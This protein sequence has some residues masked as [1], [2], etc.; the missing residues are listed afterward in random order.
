MLYSCK[1]VLGLPMLRPESW[2]AV[3]W[4]GLMS[5]VDASYTAYLVPLSFAYFHDVRI[6]N[7]MSVLDIIGSKLHCLLLRS[8]SAACLQRYRVVHQN[9]RQ[10]TRRISA[11][12]LYL[13]DV[14]FNFH[15]GIVLTKSLH[16]RLLLDG[17][18]VAKL[19]I[20]HSTFFV[21]LVA[22]I[23][24]PLEV[25]NGKYLCHVLW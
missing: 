5:I 13:L 25:S 17:V 6:F 20:K 10:M 9:R 22:A 16:S 21:D 11:G 24:L 4:K 15:I 3:L 2:V 14:L 19:Y 7:W 18:L 23:P 8:K 1:S 12:V